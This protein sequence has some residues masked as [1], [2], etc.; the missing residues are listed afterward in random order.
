[1]ITRR[2]S[3]RST[4]SRPFS[5]LNFLLR[6]REKR[7]QRRQYAEAFEV[8]ISALWVVVFGVVVLGLQ[9][10]VYRISQRLVKTQG[11]VVVG[12]IHAKHSVEVC[13]IVYA[14]ACVVQL[15]APRR[16]YTQIPGRDVARRGPSMDTSRINTL[17]AEMTP[18][19]IHNALWYVA[20]FERAGM[21]Q[22]EADEWRRR[23][24]AWQDYLGLDSRSTAA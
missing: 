16:V 20:V 1:M 19:E 4:S 17:L 5:L 24:L 10:N 22:A 12:L 18:Q 3:R 6:G 11:H 23:I 8:A 7:V 9:R 13:R 14:V 2:S 15:A 21:T